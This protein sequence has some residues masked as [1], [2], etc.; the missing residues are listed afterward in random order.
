[1]IDQQSHRQKKAD[2]ADAAEYQFK[3]T[4]SE[5]RHAP[6]SNLLQVQLYE[7]YNRKFLIVSESLNLKEKLRENQIAL[8]M[9]RY[10][11]YEMM[12]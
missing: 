8:A 7:K 12:F 2:K 6:V 9:E 1:M 4:P 10:Q 5:W 11:Y 3:I